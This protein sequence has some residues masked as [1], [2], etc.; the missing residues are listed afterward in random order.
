MRSVNSPGKQKG[1]RGRAAKRKRHAKRI[2]PFGVHSQQHRIRVASRRGG[3][4]FLRR[5]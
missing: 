1:V 3:R 2:D 4:R 5:T